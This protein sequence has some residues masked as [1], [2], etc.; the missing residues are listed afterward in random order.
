[1]ARLSITILLCSLL[2]LAFGTADQAAALSLTVNPRQATN[3][4]PLVITVRGEGFCPE[5]SDPIVGDGVVE[6]VFSDFCPILPPSPGPFEHHDL[7]GPLEPGIWEIRLIDLT[8]PVTPP[9]IVA[10]VEVTVTDPRYAIELTPSPATE[11]DE[12][13]AH[14]TFFGSCVLGHSLET[15]PGHVRI[16]LQEV[17]LCDPPQLP[18]TLE[19]DVQVGRLDAGDYLVELIYEGSRVAESQL[20]VLP[21]GACVA[22][23]TTLCL[24]DSRFRVEATWTDPSDASGAATAVAETDESGFFWFFSPNNVEL[25]VKVLDACETPFESFWVFAAGLTDVGVELVV[26]DTATDTAVSYQSPLGRRFET[27]TDTAAFDT[28]P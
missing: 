8:I 15:A 22:G 18:D 12:V 16:E 3:T 9:A 17:G 21:P 11:D 2:T 26:T 24:N 25:A 1:M 20:P 6:I 28:C 23:E 5:V 19:R 27:I 4:K 13:V 14:L 7:V 10:T